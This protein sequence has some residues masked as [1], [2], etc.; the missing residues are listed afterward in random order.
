[1]PSEQVPMEGQVEG[2]EG[3]VQGQVQGDDWPKYITIG[4]KRRLEEKNGYYYEKRR[5]GPEKEVMYELIKG[6]KENR[7][8][9]SPYCEEDEFLVLRLEKNQRDPE[10]DEER[11]IAYDSAIVGDQGDQSLYLRQPVWCSKDNILEPGEHVWQG[12]KLVK[13]S[14]RVRWTG[15]FVCETRVNAEMIDEMREGT[16]AQL[17]S[18][19]R[20][21]GE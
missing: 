15:G 13:E 17:D 2:Q 20:V 11:W 7:G 10:K 8:R 14:G 19:K 18:A 5:V 1:M 9:G 4:T 6:P 12:N 3:A 16:P 21:K